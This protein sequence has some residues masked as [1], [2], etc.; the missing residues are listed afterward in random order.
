MLIHQYEDLFK[1]KLIDLINIV[2]SALVNTSRENCQQAKL[3]QS[4]HDLLHTL[5]VTMN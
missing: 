4:M 1:K 2:N 3:Q 5:L